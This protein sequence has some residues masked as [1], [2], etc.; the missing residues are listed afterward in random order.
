MNK[1]AKKLKVSISSKIV[2]GPYGG[3]NLFVKNL[4]NYLLSEGHS[5]VHSL[6]DKDIDIILIINPLLD[7]ATFTYSHFDALY[8]S[9]FININSRII[10]RIN[11]CD[12]R[13]NTNYVN[14][15]IIDSSKYADFRVFVSNWLQNLYFGK[16]VD[17]ENSLVIMSGSDNSIFYPDIKDYN[18]DESKVKLVTHHW[19]N[20]WN[21]GFEIFNK[22][23]LLLDNPNL[24]SI[25][26]FTFIGNVNKSS[27]FKN[28]LVKPPMDGAE[29]AIELRKYDG[30]LT[31]SINEPSGN[32]HIEAAQCGLPI[33]YLN[34]GGL[35]EYCDGYGVVF[36]KKNF[37]EKLYE[38]I[39]KIDLYKV[40]VQQYP[41][42]STKM[43]Q[44]YLSLFYKA[45]SKDNNLINSYSKRHLNL[46]KIK[47]RL[48][49]KKV[50]LSAKVKYI[51]S[52]KK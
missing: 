15:Q 24:N 10:Q 13:K 16:G 12:E 48:K 47:F 19:S 25:F 36:S 46:L 5:V 44:Q 2:D 32:H 7:S 37:E 26:S 4:K 43:C 23:D 49:R 14:K 40:K 29:L 45:L 20:H 34:S 22:L 52:K 39:E 28:I 38:F 17:K 30:Y 9:N 3:G 18:F 6:K 50:L 31:A 8:Y 27:N 35:P 41:F 33:M 21:K 1:E 51:V 42:N 11:E